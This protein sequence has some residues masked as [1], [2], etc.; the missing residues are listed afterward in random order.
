MQK[1]SK[2]IIGLVQVTFCG[3]RFW[4][5]RF[6]HSVKRFGRFGL[7]T[8]VNRLLKGDSVIEM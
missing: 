4:S 6:K 2:I 5:N 1:I 3:L 8:L 7:D